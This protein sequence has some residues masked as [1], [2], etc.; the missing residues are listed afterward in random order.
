ME[1]EIIENSMKIDQL[2]QEHDVVFLLTDSRESRW[3]P[4]LLANTYN[5]LCISVGLGFDS[6]L[7]IRHGRSSDEK[8]LKEKEEEFNKILEEVKEDKTFKGK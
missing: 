2:V 1:K 3:Y 6:Y 4:T 7:L 5:K 8:Y